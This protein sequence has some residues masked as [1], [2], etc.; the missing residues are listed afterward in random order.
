MVRTNASN[1]WS[2]SLR[3]SVDCRI[4]GRVNGVTLPAVP[5]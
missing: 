2:T 3:T 1:V 5:T 4:S